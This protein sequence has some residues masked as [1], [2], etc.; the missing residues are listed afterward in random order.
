[1]KSGQCLAG[2]GIFIL[3]M[4]NGCAWQ[5]MPDAPRFQTSN[6]IPL[7]VGVEL[8][9]DEVSLLYG[10]S[11]IKRLKEWGVFDEIKFPYRRGDAVDGVLE[12]AIK[13]QWI[14]GNNFL[15]GFIVGASLFTLSPFLGSSITGTHRLESRLLR[16]DDEVA[17]YSVQAK[18]RVTAGLM[19]D[20]GE[21]GRDA[22]L[23]QV[24]TLASQLAQRLTDDW[25]RHSRSFLAGQMKAVEPQ[26]E[27]EPVA[28]QNDRPMGT[29]VVKKTPTG[30]LRL[31]EKATTASPEAGRVYP[32]TELILLDE[33]DRWDKV[34]LISGVEGYVLKLY[35]ERKN[36]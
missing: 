30:F 9:N 36:P 29:V 4:V 7:K 34:R 1:M 18:N 5:R 31:R 16:N 33:S 21:V 25:P 28:A 8:A 11:V 19:A 23:L 6:S 24:N 17:S 10:V 3:T 13:G 2:C 27:R 35:V 22:D 26:V 14:P 15:S 20:W 12:I 32:G